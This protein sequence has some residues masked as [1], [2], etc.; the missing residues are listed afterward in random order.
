MTVA[1]DAAAR[2]FYAASLPAEYVAIQPFDELHPLYRNEWREKVLAP[3]V[4]A[5]EA[6]PDRRL[7]VLPQLEAVA[8]AL[9]RWNTE[10][11]QSLVIAVIARNVRRLIDDIREATS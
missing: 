2:A 1:V 8:D 7:L 6:V 4:A 10:P 11:D 9:D 5:V 3:A